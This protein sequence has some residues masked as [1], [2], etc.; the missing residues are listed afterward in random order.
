MVWRLI[1]PQIEHKV[2][3]HVMTVNRHPP[4][5]LFSG[6]HFLSATALRCPTKRESPQFVQSHK[7]MAQDNKS[8]N[9]FIG[10]TLFSAR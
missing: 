10:K 2:K 7:V 3:V 6:L 4:G 1:K 8:V 9:G 5:Q